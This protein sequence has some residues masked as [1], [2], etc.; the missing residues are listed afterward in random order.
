MVLVLELVLRLARKLVQIVI[1]QVED[2]V[3]VVRADVKVVKDV[4]AL[5][6]VVVLLVLAAVLEDVNQDVMDVLL[7][8]VV[9]VIV[10]IVDVVEDVAADVRELVPGIAVVAVKDH[11]LALVQAAKVLVKLTVH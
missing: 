11:V 1:V 7:V 10:V 9:L 8:E 3:V 4:L 5:V 2:A 6:V